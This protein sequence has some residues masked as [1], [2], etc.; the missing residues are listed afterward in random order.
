MLGPDHASLAPV[1]NTAAIA[2]KGL[3]RLEEAEAH[4]P[5]SVA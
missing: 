3:G 4:L 1:Y 5:R 2:L